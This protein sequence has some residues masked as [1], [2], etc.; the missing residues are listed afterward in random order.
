M[1][2]EYEAGWYQRRFGLSVV[3]KII[4]SLPEFELRIF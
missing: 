4:L 3:E 2:I 1:P